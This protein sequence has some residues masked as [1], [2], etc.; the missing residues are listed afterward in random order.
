[1]SDSSRKDDDDTKEFKAFDP[2]ATDEMEAVTLPDPTHETGEMQALDP[3]EI[4]QHEDVIG[5]LKRDAQLLQQAPDNPDNQGT[6]LYAWCDHML[7]NLIQQNP[8]N[9]ATLEDVDMHYVYRQYI[10]GQHVIDI[11]FYHNLLH[12]SIDATK[13]LVPDKIHSYSV[14]I[15]YVD[16][17]NG[18]KGVIV[19]SDEYLQHYAQA[20]EL[21]R[22]AT[23]AELLGGGE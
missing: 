4:A 18:W 2:D 14:D 1:M 12:K 8:D 7:E 23:D 10:E 17:K 9:G 13:D 16:E 21:H 11:Q 6:L 22:I 20:E 3:A 15:E 5:L 19:V